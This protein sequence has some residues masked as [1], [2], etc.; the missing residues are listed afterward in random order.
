MKYVH[1]L[2]RVTELLMEFPF[3]NMNCSKIEDMFSDRKR[4][5]SGNYPSC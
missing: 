5:P 4:D 1:L 2:R 3:G